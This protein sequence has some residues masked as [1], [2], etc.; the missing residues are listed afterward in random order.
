MFSSFI[1][2]SVVILFHIQVVEPLVDVCIV[3]GCQLL[4]WVD[5]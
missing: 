3:G 4:R 2:D 5:R 1:S